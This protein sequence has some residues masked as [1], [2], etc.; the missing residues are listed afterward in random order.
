MHVLVSRSSNIPGTIYEA[1]TGFNITGV[2]KYLTYQRLVSEGVLSPVLRANTLRNKLT[3]LNIVL[4]SLRGPFDRVFCSAC[5]TLF[6][7]LPSS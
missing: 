4:Q 2:W 6:W 5:R 1:L 3:C 7:A